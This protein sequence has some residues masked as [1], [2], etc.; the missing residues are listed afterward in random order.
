MRVLERAVGTTPHTPFLAIFSHDRG[1]PGKQF[2]GKKHSFRR[3]FKNISFR[4][5]SGLTE[6]LIFKDVL[7]V[8]Q[9]CLKGGLKEFQGYYKKIVRAIKCCFK[10]VC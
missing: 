8:F 7:S 5:F 3:K 10:Q 6:K 1:E 2:L 4:K 9:R